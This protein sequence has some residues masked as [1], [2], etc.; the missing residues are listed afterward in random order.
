M[1]TVLLACRCNFSAHNLCLR[2][3]KKISGS[4]V[5]PLMRTRN[6]CWIAEL[7]QYETDYVLETPMRCLQCGAETNE[8]TLVD[9]E[10]I[11]VRVEGFR[12]EGKAVSDPG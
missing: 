11:F 8:K 3:S 6:K 10:Q 12:R 9:W 2:F 1:F 4:S 5:F 7:N